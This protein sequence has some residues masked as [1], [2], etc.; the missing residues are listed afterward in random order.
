M[1]LIKI[2][3]LPAV[4]ALP[5][6][7]YMRHI[8]LLPALGFTATFALAAW[9]LRAVTSSGALA[10]L[11][12][13]AIICVAAGTPGFMAVLTLFLLTFLAT[14]FGYSRKLRYG[15]AERGRSGAQVL[16]NLGVATMTIAPLLFWRSLSWVLLVGFTAAL[17]EAAADTVSSEIGQ[18]LSPRRAYLITTYERVGAGSNGGISLAGCMA[19]LIASGLVAAVCLCFDLLVPRWFWP[20]TLCGFAGMLLDSLL[21]A[22]LERPEKLGNNSVNFLSTAFSAF[23]AILMAFLSR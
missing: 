10:G 8:E 15:R 11:L 13:S 2:A 21:G 5:F 6:W 19:G 17:A 3:I 7:F 16:A 22:T 12:L 23:V 20:V 14:R 4:T 18:V 9:G 1:V